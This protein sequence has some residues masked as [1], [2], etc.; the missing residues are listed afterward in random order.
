MGIGELKDC[1]NQ[2]SPGKHQFFH[3]LIEEVY[4]LSLTIKYSYHKSDDPNL[5]FLSLYPSTTQMPKIQFRSNAKP[6]VYAYPE[7]L[8]PPK[9]EEKEKVSTA[10]LSITAKKAKQ[11]REAKED[12]AME[13]VRATQLLFSYS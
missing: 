9:K 11:K 12:D 10:I 4:T 5:Y 2:S 7:P 13:V 8:Q 1:G 3:L 6:S